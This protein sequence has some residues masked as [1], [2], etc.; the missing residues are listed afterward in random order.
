MSSDD[1]E[2]ERIFEVTG[3][4]EQQTPVYR[5]NRKLFC[6]VTDTNFQCFQD[7]LMKNHYETI[8]LS[9][10]KD[11][12]VLVS[13]ARP[14]FVVNYTND[15]EKAVVST[16]FTKSKHEAQKWICA[17]SLEP[18]K[19]KLNLS[20]FNIISRIGSGS[21]GTVYLAQ[22]KL[23]G[24]YYALKC[25]DKMRISNDARKQMYV[26]SERNTLMRAQHNFIIRLYHAFQ[27]P[28]NLFFVLEFGEGGDLRYHLN[29][30]NSYFTE[31]QIKL[32]LAEI[33]LGLIALHNIGIVYRDLKPENILLKSNGHIKL[34]D[35]GTCRQIQK[36]SPRCS[37]CGTSEYVAPEVLAKQPYTIAVD[38]WSYGILAF[39]LF[40][41]RVPFQSGSAPML[42]RKIQNDPIRWREAVDAKTKAFI[43]ELLEKNPAKRLG[44]GGPDEVLNHP[45]FEDMDWDKV[46]N[47]E[48]Q[49]DFIPEYD[50]STPTINFPCSSEADE[51][52][53]GQDHGRIECFSYQDDLS[54][55]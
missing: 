36:D 51:D 55:I 18:F 48:Y 10:I 24:E 19:H 2:D 35:F 54:K 21:Y 47:L 31:Y 8:P 17:L 6:S 14:G 44:T 49:P 20:H 33:A 27:T 43:T 50:Q 39:E 11:V 26:Q 28:A 38:W 13:R 16:F 5:T 4:L 40:C 41:G 23:D 42:F 1:E 15:N 30:K 37:F 7:E 22:N 25:I 34:A 12:C 53:N 52:L 32:Y 45:F 3:W 46:R 9:R 29:N